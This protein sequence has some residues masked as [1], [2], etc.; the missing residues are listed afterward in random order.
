MLTINFNQFYA[1][2]WFFQVLISTRYDQ[3]TSVIYGSDSLLSLANHAIS[4][5]FVPELSIP[6]DIKVQSNRLLLGS[7]PNLNTKYSGSLL[8]EYHNQR[9]KL[10]FPVGLAMINFYSLD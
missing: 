5:S 6:P 2:L 9:Y 3:L 7:K 10:T 1:K 4:F 8:F